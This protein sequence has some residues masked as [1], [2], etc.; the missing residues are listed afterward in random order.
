MLHMEICAAIVNATDL[1]LLLIAVYTE[2]L[3]A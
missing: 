3:I 1:S 2:F